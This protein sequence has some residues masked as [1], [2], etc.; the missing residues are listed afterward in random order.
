[1]LEQVEGEKE[2]KTVFEGIESQ[3]DRSLNVQKNAIEKELVEKLARE[4]EEAR[5]RI[6]AAEREIA[7]SRRVLDGHRSALA[8][9]KVAK[10]QLQNQIKGH[11]ERASS[12]Q[13]M[14]EKMSTQAYEEYEKVSHLG[15][16]LDGIRQRAEHETSLLRKHLEEKYGVRADFQSAFEPSET[17]TE[18]RQ[19]MLKMKKVREMLSAAS[20]LRV[21]EQPVET[22]VETQAE[23]LAESPVETPVAPPVEKPVERPVLRGHPEVR[24]VEPFEPSD[25]PEEQNLQE[26]TETAPGVDEAEDP[27][28]EEIRMLSAEL[29]QY[30]RTE[31]VF[32]GTEFAYFQKGKRMVLDG[33]AFVGTL[34][35]VS[36]VAKGL[37]INLGQ[38]EMSKDMFLIKQEILN[39]QEI[40]R[41]AFLR[42]VRFCEKEDGAL[43][44]GVSDVLNVRAM[45]DIL[46]RLTFGNWSNP[47]DFNGFLDHV[48]FLRN[49]FRV[50]IGESR[51][52][53]KSILEQLEG[54]ALIHS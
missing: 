29:A 13:Q 17:L 6:E 31:P 25:V 3:L 39:Q 7:D 50:K 26:E 51:E 14:M 18:I 49:A 11:L 54:G 2:I 46:E 12:C 16:E 28:T 52:Y 32:N 9:L 43:P 4:K 33:E 24:F 5:K 34:N 36:D 30:R 1:M 10:E 23:A 45:K 27:E 41:K 22:P 21:P 38:K 40:L 8:E 53:L 48:A 20:G 15:L 44:K 42:V 19:E 37:H 35:R 47:A